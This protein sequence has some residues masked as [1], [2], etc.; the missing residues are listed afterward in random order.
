MLTSLNALLNPS[1]TYQSKLT[2]LP[3]EFKQK[4]SLKEEIGKE[5]KN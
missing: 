4:L 3:E 5:S 2:T 1:Q